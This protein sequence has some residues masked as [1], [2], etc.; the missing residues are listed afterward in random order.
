LRVEDE[1][2]VRIGTQRS[3]VGSGASAL[4]GGETS[5][6]RAAAHASLAAAD[7]LQLAQN[8]R[9]IIECAWIAVGV[10]DG[11]CASLSVLIALGLRPR[12]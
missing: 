8:D 3:L 9:N 10:L 4:W 5:D 12:P 6:F 2:L 11:G 7:D 1:S